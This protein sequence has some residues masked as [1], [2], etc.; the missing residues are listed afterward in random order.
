M[1]PGR[2]GRASPDANP[3]AARSRLL[4][5]DWARASTGSDERAA[6]AEPHHHELVD[7]EV[8]HQSE[9]IVRIRLPRPLNLD[10][11][12]GLTA[13]RVAQ[14]RGDAAI[15]AL[16]LFNRVERRVA[17][18]ERNRRVQAAAWK[19]QERNAR[20]GLLEVNANGALFVELPGSPVARLLSQHAWD[21][22][23]RRGRGTRCQ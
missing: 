13:R 4:Q 22:G 5:Y 18:E 14:V 1:R 7:A 21:G 23:R 10:R 6:D 17:G 20:P 3:P 19:Q 11:S 8:I 16:E 2:H 9:L 15:L 12:R